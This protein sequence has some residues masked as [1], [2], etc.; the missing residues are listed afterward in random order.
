M[1]QMIHLLFDETD[2]T[3]DINLCQNVQNRKI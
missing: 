2:D 1:K 3:F